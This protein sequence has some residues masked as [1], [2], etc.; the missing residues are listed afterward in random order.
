MYRIRLFPFAT[1]FM[2]HSRHHAVLEGRNQVK[3]MV[4]HNNLEWDI[5]DLPDDGT[6]PE[7]E[8][9][10]VAIDTRLLDDLAEE[11]EVG[12]GPVAQATIATLLKKLREGRR[13]IELRY[14]SDDPDYRYEPNDGE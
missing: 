12:L 8:E 3:S 11:A 5:V 14:P 4:D 7:F 13:V 9:L 6:G 1:S 10:H 2:V